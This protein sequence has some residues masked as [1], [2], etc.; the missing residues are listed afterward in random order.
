MLKLFDFN[1]CKSENNGYISTDHE[2]PPQAPPCLPS[3]SIHHLPNQSLSPHLPSPPS[4]VLPSPSLDYPSH[5]L[6]YLR[7]E[8]AHSH[9]TVCPPR[10]LE[11]DHRNLGY[12][13]ETQGHQGWG[14]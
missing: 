11:I 7:L 9:Q 3:H 1:L 5:S 8:R 12:F 13:L 10:N 4:H 2:N 6:C 14:L